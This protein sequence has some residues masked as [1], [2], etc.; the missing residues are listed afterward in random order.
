MQLAAAMT[1]APAP[2]VPVYAGTAARVVKLSHAGAAHTQTLRHRPAPPA[3]HLLAC[4]ARRPGGALRHAPNLACLRSFAPRRSQLPS[5]P[6]P[7]P[8]SPHPHTPTPTHTPP[9][10]SGLQ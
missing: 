1:G 7:R 10:W 6:P 2:V 3:A 8:P 5:Q 9:P 4:T